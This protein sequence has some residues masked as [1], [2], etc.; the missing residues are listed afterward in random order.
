MGFKFLFSPKPI[1]HCALPFRRF[2]SILAD[3]FLS[4]APLLNLHLHFLF[5][6]AKSIY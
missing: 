6:N 3:L 4:P 2:L 5:F 1:A